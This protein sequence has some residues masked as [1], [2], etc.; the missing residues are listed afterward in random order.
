MTWFIRADDS[1]RYATGDFASG[2]LRSRNTWDTLSSTGHEL[3]WHMHLM[4]YDASQRCYSFASEPP[5]LDV[6]FS[7]L[8]QYFN[9]RATRTGWDFCSDWL[10][11]HLDELGIVVDLSALPG[12]VAWH[13]AGKTKI[14]VDWL[15]TQSW[16]Y[17]PAIDDYQRNGTLTIVE[18]PIT[19]FPNSVGG[20]ARRV[21]WRLRHGCVSVKGLRSRHKMLTEKWSRSPSSDSGVAAFFFHPSD[22]TA[23]GRENFR[24]NLRLLRAIPEAEFV[25]ASTVASTISA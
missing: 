7:A 1:V 15:S 12:N 6:A 21:V 13:M 18:V 8:N 22:L 9:V 17:H 4:S 23:S 5:W 25:T 11:R 3:G 14:R 2:Y 24:V 20:M 19:A 10:M 16:P